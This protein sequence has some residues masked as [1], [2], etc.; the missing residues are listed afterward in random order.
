ML[1]GYE[2]LRKLS[3]TPPPLVRAAIER[4]V[5]FYSAAGPAEDAAS[6]RTR[7][8]EFDAARPGN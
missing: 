5:S 8:R 1:T 3:A 2:G 4:L 7:L 6:W